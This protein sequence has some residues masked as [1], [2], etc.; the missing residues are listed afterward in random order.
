MGILFRKEGRMCFGLVGRDAHLGAADA[1]LGLS[2]R[3]GDVSEA[4]IDIVAVPGGVSPVEKTS[5]V[6][7]GPEGGKFPATLTRAPSTRRVRHAE[8]SAV[9]VLRPRPTIAAT[10]LLHDWREAGERRSPARPSNNC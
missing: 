5:T 3:R 8:S 7:G 4:S 6:T 2:T 1:V 10:A 9:S